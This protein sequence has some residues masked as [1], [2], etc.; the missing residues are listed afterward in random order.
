MDQTA[1]LDRLLAKLPTVKNLRGEDRPSLSAASIESARK[2]AR[3]G[4]LDL[5][6]FAAA[7]HINAS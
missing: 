3:Q 1:E 7:H 5:V 6:R 2:Q 4:T